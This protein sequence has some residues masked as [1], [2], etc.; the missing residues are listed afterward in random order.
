MK[1]ILI[2]DC[3]GQGVTNSSQPWPIIVIDIIS[4]SKIGMCFTDL[5]KLLDCIIQVESSWNP[6]AVSE[7]GC[8]GLC[9]ISAI[10]LREYNEINK[11]RTTSTIKK[12]EVYDC[13]SESNETISR[14]LC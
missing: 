9:Q 5:D 14:Q 1:Y 7:D 4:S 12:K 13:H 6:V 2:S 3:G 10:V 8:V 11:T